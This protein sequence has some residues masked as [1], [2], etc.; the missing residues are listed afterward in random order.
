MRP[1]V[2]FLLGLALVAAGCGATADRERSSAATSTLRAT[3]VDRHGDGTLALGPGRPMVARTDLAPAARPGR[4]LATVA[5][6]TDAHVRDAESPARAG[7]LDR[8]GPP[9]NSTF[10]PQEALSAQVL[11]GAVGAIDAARPDAVVEGG[12]LIDNDEADELDRGLQV[13]HGGMVRP[14]SGA[15]GYEGPQSSTDADPGFYRP[16]VD[17]PRH[18]DLLRRAIAPFR[19]PGLRAPWFPVVGNHD[20]LVQGVVP[21]SP[22]LERLAVGDRRLVEP[23]RSQLRAARRLRDDP[24]AAVA[25]LLRGGLPGRTSR[26]AP[27]PRRRLLRPE[28]LVDRLRASSAAPDR[29]GPRLDYTFDV[30]RFVR[31]IVLDG[32]RRDA[33]AFTLAPAHLGWL[34]RQLR[35]AGRRW[36]L[37]FSHTPLDRTPSGRAALALLDRDPHVVAALAGDTHHNRIAPRRTRAGGYWLIETGSLADW[38]MQSR[39]LRLAQTKRGLALQTWMLDTA[40][41]PESLPGIARQLAYLDAQGG[42]PN[43]FAGGRRDRNA[44]LYLDKRPARRGTPPPAR[45]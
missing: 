17:A 39:M 28:E 14:D 38:P 32:I 2:A 9:F 16:G 11:A 12:D 1:T 20:V 43:G 15:R 4:T 33:N 35:A 13:L 42:R 18:P 10:R 24:T 5:F 29:G 6:F 19:S 22:A 37:L 41:G 31:G 36:V 3:W 8:L 27:D 34:A 23:D 7:L 26:I 30:G 21:P 40:G 45:A 44:V 25:S